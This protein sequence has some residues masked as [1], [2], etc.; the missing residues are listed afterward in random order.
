MNKSKKCKYKRREN[1]NRGTL[2][3][4]QHPLLSKKEKTMGFLNRIKKAAML[5]QP[6]KSGLLTISMS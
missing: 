3:V 4:V 2:A 5:N 6:K 1:R